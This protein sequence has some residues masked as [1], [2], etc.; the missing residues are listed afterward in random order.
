MKR[1]KQTMKAGTYY[2]GDPLFVVEDRKLWIEFIES[3]IEFPYTIKFSSRS[4][5]SFHA[6]LTCY[7][8]GEFFD[9]E[10]YF[11]QVISG[12]LGIVSKED[13]LKMADEEIITELNGEHSPQFG[14]FVTFEEDFD[15]VFSSDSQDAHQFGH[16]IIETGK[17]GLEE[18]DFSDQYYE[19]E[20]DQSYDQS[21]EELIAE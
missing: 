14:R 3:V 5:I 18:E 9:N 4:G 6:Y 12:L 7:G 17:D 20:Y 10:G 2:I 11:Y 13:V 21:F 16:L 1:M 15:V 19:V 8:V